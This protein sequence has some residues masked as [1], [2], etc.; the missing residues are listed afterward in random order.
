[1]RKKALLGIGLALFAGSTGTAQFATDRGPVT[2]PRATALPPGLSPVGP[3]APATPT[4]PTVPGAG[5]IQPASGFQP[6]PVATPRTATVTLPA[7]LE[8]KTALSAD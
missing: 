2:P 4:P 8:I 1:M 5:Y 6:P 3:A 7:S